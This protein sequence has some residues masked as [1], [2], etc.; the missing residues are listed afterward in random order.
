MRVTVVRPSELGP[1]EAALWSKFQHSARIMLSPYFS[2]TYARAIDQCRSTARVAVV[3]DQ[4]QIIAFLPFELGTHGVA[5]P[6]GGPMNNLHGFIGSGSPLAA[7]RVARKAGIRAWRFTSAPA[8]QHALVPFHEMAVQCPVIDLSTGYEKS[9]SARTKSRRALERHLGTI[10]L[11][12]SCSGS[13]FIGQ[14]I[15]WKSHKYDG[16]RALFRDPTARSIIE[17]LAASDKDDCQGV[18]SVLFAGERPIAIHLGLLGPEM[19]AGW[20]TAYDPELGKFAPGMIMWLPLAQAAERAGVSQID[21][22]FS[23]NSYKFDLAN[24]SYVTAAGTVWVN[25]TEEFLRGAYRR[26]YYDRSKQARA[27]PGQ[28]ATEPND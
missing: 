8:E 12:W 18:V 27:R 10:S 26:L 21:L 5:L 16:T 6:I 25:R 22:G 4:G 2:L 17:T 7:R 24:S 19:L 23:Q 28:D 15:N 13:D 3:E 11:E 20:F 14:L 1:E 9:L